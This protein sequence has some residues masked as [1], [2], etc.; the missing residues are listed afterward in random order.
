MFLIELSGPTKLGIVSIEAFVEVLAQTEFKL[1]KGQWWSSPYP[2]KT[3]AKPLNSSKFPRYLS[4]GF[5]Q[6][7]NVNDKAFESG[8]GS[9]LSLCNAFL[10]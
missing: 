10:R 9:F 2:K 5:K 8:G 3:P 1:P 6:A 4:L 7:A